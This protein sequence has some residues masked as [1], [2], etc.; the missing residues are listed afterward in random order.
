MTSFI[1]FP[2]SLYSNERRSAS[3]FR[4]YCVTSFPRSSSSSSDLGWQ[5]QTFDIKMIRNDHKCLYGTTVS[6]RKLHTYSRVRERECVSMSHIEYL[7]FY[8]ALSLRDLFIG[9]TY[10]RGYNWRQSD[11]HKTLYSTLR[12]SDVVV[13]LPLKSLLRLHNYT[14]RKPMG[15]K[16]KSFYSCNL[17]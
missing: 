13:F 9:T 17:A 14:L 7:S 12:P 8:I 10:R 3:C 1:G 5:S 16:K 15:R 2:S 4:F 6:Y 11:F